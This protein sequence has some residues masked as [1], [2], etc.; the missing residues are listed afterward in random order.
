MT[1]DLDE[2]LARFTYHQPSNEDVRRKLEANRDFCAQLA[3]ALLAN[4]PES[5]E[6]SLALTNL[7]Q[8]CMYAN[9]AVARHQ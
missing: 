3:M 7:D 1:I 4:C 9:A 6:L 5:R 8:V 2:L